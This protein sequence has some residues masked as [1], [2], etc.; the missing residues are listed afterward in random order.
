MSKDLD[1]KEDK[2]STNRKKFLAKGLAAIIIFSTVGVGLGCSKQK[3][4]DLKNNV[5]DKGKNIV[6]KHNDNAI[7]PG[8]NIIY[9]SEKY[10]VNVNDVS[11]ML[12]GETKD[13]EKYVFLT[14]DDGPST[15]TDKVLD[16][17]KKENVKATFF[18][19]GE[20]LAEGE[21][22][23]N[24]LKRTISE[25]HAIANHSYTH[26]LKKLYPNN[27]ID[28]DYFMS[29]FNKTN[30]LMKEILGKDF[31]TR[32][33]RLP[34]GYNSR[35]YYKDP[36]LGKFNKRLE[37]DSIVSIDWNALNGDA[38]G[39]PYSVDEL[40]NYAK[41]TSK[42]KNKIVILMHDAYGKGKTVEALPEIIKYYKDNGYAFKIMT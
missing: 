26:S 22:A 38:E 29:E 23:Q 41:K 25:G 28:V 14:F 31:N 40:I 3:L 27:K 15:N 33:L 8:K 34:G 4:N 1:E 5:V 17:L 30:D 6:Q 13:R 7:V 32:V 24:R 18:V 42:N 16:I 11:K 2:F 37:K 20:R 19:L 39:K 35:V 36:M 21:A 9:A 10:A 12:N